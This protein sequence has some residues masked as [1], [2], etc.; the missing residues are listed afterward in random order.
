MS[1]ELRGRI[2]INMG[3]LALLL[4]DVE[5]ARASYEHAVELLDSVSD[6]EALTIALHNLALSH[7][8]EQNWEA[9]ETSFER[10]LAMA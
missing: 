4:G 6:E 3:A 5:Q 10:C 8:E 2:Q 1:A 7:A 9:A